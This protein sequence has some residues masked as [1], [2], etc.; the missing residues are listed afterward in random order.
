MNRRSRQ[1]LSTPFYTQSCTFRFFASSLSLFSSIAIA[2]AATPILFNC[3]TCV[4]VMAMIKWSYHYD[5]VWNARIL[6]EGAPNGVNHL[7]CCLSQI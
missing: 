1:G 5:H 7:A 2:V 6:Y 4:F 3:S